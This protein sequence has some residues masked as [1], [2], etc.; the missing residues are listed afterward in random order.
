[1]ISGNEPRHP[2]ERNV[3]SGEGTDTGFKYGMGLLLTGYALILL[4]LGEP[5]WA[6][7]PAV[8]A[9]AILGSCL[10]NQIFKG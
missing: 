5:I 1:V 6:I 8:A 10:H 4:Y 7:L 9:V 2:I 3:R